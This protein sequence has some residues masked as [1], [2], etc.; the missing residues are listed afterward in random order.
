LVAIARAIASEPSVLLLDEPAAGLNETETRELGELIR[1]LCQDWG[2]GI[3]LVEHDVSLLM[4]TCDRIVALD[5]GVVITSGAPSEV[6]ADPRVIA[7][8]LGEVEPD[9]QPLLSR[10]ST[11]DPQREPL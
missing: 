5:F 4:S 2:M 7:S 8:Y 6:R 3:L 11:T 1:R 9:A 10:R